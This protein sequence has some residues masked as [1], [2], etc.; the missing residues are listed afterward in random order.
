MGEAAERM[1]LE[2]EGP[3]GSTRKQNE[4]LGSDGGLE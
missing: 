2:K 3:G 4:G 1:T